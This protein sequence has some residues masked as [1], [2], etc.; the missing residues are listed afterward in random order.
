MRL[1]DADKLKELFEDLQIT[2]EEDLSRFKDE[3]LHSPE[4]YRDTQRG[5]VEGVIDCIMDLEQAETVEAIPIDFLREWFG[6][7][8]NAFTDLMIQWEKENEIDRCRWI[9]KEIY[10]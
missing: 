4:R 5:R 8:Y 1:I 10:W 7:N 9:E 3:E 6:C 2:F